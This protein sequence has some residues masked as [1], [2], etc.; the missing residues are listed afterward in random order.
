MALPYPPASDRSAW[1]APVSLSLHNA[2]FGTRIEVAQLSLR[3]ES[4]ELL[5]NGAFRAGL[6]HWFVTSDVHL[7]WRALNTPVQVLFEQGLLGAAG[8]VVLVIAVI[9]RQYVITSPAVPQASI[10]AGWAGI[11]ALA[12]FDSLLDSPRAILLLSL[13]AAPLIPLMRRARVQPRAHAPLR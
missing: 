6:D 10:A 1:S 4:G 5:S 7:A 3:S 9:R 13:L 2:A 8:L 12:A 11:L